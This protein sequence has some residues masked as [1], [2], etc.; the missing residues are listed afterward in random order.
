MAHRAVVDLAGQ[1]DRAARDMEAVKLR[2]AGH[3]YDE[4]ASALGYS[5]R[6]RAHT[7]VKDAMIRAR[8]E[9]YGEADLY[10]VE[11]LDRL[12]A[13]LKALWPRAEKGDDKAVAECRR[14]ISAMDDL[15]GAKAPVKLE[16]GEGD[17]DRAIRELD[18]EIDRRAR[19]V[20]GEIPDA[21]D[22]AG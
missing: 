5:S 6:G 22:T 17:V 20:A 3:T 16:I 12:T 4:I 8:E 15:T 21:T 13:L 11:S 18:A 7:A 1:A 2:R 14:L 19:E 10:R 9:L